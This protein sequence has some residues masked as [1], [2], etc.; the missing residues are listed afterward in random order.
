MGKRKRLLYAPGSELPLGEAWKK[1]GKY[2]HI[3]D[4][5]ITNQIMKHIMV[6]KY[7]KTKNSTIVIGNQ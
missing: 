2:I 3:W 4:T 1:K 7:A 5:E 6:T